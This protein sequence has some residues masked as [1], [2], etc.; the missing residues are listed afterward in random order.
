MKKKKVLHVTGQLSIGGAENVAMNYSRYIDHDKFESH[1]LVYG[2]ET[3]DYD[4]EVYALGGKIVRVNYSN[5]NLY[6]FYRELCALFKTE[7]YDIVHGHTMFNNGTV[8]LAAKHAGVPERITHAHSI[9]N[10]VSTSFFVS[11]YENLM[12]KLIIDNSTGFV[13]CSELAGNFLFGKDKFKHRGKVVLNG[14]S[15]EKFRFNA[16][17]RDTYRQQLGNVENK[18]VLGHSG[19]LTS[20]KNQQHL[21]EVLAKLSD[22][23]YILV[24]LGDGEDKAMLADYAE[25][26]GVQDQVLFLGNVNNVNEWLNAFDI[27][28][29]PSLF[30]GLGVSVI[31]AQANG[32]PC[33][34]SDNLPPEVLVTDLVK[35]ISL[36]DVEAWVSA[37]KNHPI[38]ERDPVYAARVAEAGYGVQKS[39]NYVQSLYEGKAQA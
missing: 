19:H 23:K 30:E 34:I 33:I 35:V 27:F 22:V 6:G 9:Q 25:K 20:V 2:N 8:M 16:E 11:H 5:K 12:R 38:D 14:I 36:A 31:E 32:L 37:V 29:F 15:T 7:K 26:L 28:V 18:I 4:D 17:L 3:Y 39:V 1:Y 13:A 21:I 10:K 24:L